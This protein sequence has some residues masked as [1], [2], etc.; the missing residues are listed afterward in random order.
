MTAPTGNPRVSVIVPVRDRRSLLRELLHALEAQTFR[1]FEVVVVDDGSSDGSD[2]EAEHATV[3]GRPVRL[4]RLHRLGAVAAREEGVAAA[5]ADVLAFTDSDCAPEPQ[6]L[7][8][9]MGAIDDGV[10][11]VHGRTVPARPMRPLERSV[12]A[13]DEGLFPTCNIFY[14]RS[15]FE[16]VGGFDQAAARRLGFRMNARVRG[17]GFGEDTLLGWRVSRS[18]GAVR[19][20][21]DAV[22]RHHV[23]PSDFKDWVSRCWMAAAFPA[24]LAD[25]PELRARM[26]RR[27]VLFGER[28]RVPMYAAGLA[29]AARRPRLATAAA[30]WWVLTR[31]R[32]LRRTPATVPE[33]LVALPQELS[34]DVVTGTALAVG[35]VRARTVVL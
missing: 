13:G 21:P 28:S 22:V 11:M 17:L 4:I 27:G 1:D 35:S 16:A 9:G 19:Y 10:D 31:W 15:A 14:R 34:L 32:D 33:Q 20:A 12:G 2:V 18:G 7:E 24:L 26:V 29:L 8:S 3:A 30:A 5:A 6:W 23:F 25:V